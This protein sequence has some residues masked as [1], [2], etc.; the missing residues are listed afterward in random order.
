MHSTTNTLG[1]M[2]SKTIPQ[3]VMISTLYKLHVETLTNDF[4]PGIK[5]SKL[6]RFSLFAT[7]DGKQT[8]KK[9]MNRIY[10]DSSIMN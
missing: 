10:I 3:N 9:T 7:D 5:T 2:N 6:F 4:G 8:N 1:T